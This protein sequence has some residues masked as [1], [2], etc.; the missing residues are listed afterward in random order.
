M[1][2]Y[3]VDMEPKKG[4][5]S[6]GIDSKMPDAPKKR[7]RS[8]LLLN[9]IAMLVVIFLLLLLVVFGLK[10]YTRHGAEVRVPDLHGLSERA[11][12]SKLELLGLKASIDDSVYVKTL[13]ADAVY[14]QSVSAGERVKTGRVIRLTINSGSAPQLVLPDIA[15]N[16][17]LREATA[18]LTSLGFK[19]GPVEY[20]GGE[21]DWL[22]EVKCNGH[23]VGTGSRIGADDEVV[24]VVG[25]GSYYDDDV[26]MQEDG[27]SDDSLHMYMESENE[28]LDMQ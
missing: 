4:E 25:S 17:S 8:V 22:Y 14:E 1:Q 5:Q 24:L 18:R 16:C 2:K 20:I 21:K 7:K 28:T 27:M 19:L 9:I 26:E 10:F 6:N 3:T 12:V 23:N 15:D 11:A 13:P